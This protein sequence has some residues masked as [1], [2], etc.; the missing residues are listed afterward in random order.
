MQKYTLFPI[1]PKSSDKFSAKNIDF[2]SGGE[3]FS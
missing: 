1:P 3:L 2:I